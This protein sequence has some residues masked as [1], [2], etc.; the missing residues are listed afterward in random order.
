[1]LGYWQMNITTWIIKLYCTAYSI[2]HDG[3]LFVCVFLY[4]FLGGRYS[5]SAH[6]CSSFVG[7]PLAGWRS[8]ITCVLFLLELRSFSFNNKHNTVQERRRK[9]ERERERERESNLPEPQQP[10]K[11]EEM[12]WTSWFP[13]KWNWTLRCQLKKKFIATSPDFG[14]YHFYSL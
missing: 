14:H 10:E 7:F 4:F 12:S 9:R 1:M 13:E 2:Y 8:R 11:K 3:F 5:V 6:Q